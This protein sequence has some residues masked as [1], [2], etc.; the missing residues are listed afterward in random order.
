MHI[1]G[2]NAMKLEVNHRNTFGKPKNTWRLRNILLKNELVNQEIKE[3][4][5]ASMKANENENMIVQN[6]W[7]MAKVIIRGTHIRKQT[8]LKK[9][10]RSQIYNLTLHLK[11]LKKEQQVKF[12]T[13]R[14][15][16]INNRA[17]IS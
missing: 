14:S 5:K 12:K 1:S 8:F 17:Q 16:I 7:D 4:I 2:H 3:E 13:S 10:E 6:H 11:E 9:Q 15:E